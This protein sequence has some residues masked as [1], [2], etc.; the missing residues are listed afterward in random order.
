[1]DFGRYL[2]QLITGT[3][4]NAMGVKRKSNVSSSFTEPCTEKMGNTATEVKVIV[5]NTIVNQVISSDSIGVN[6]PR[7]KLKYHHM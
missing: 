4:G 7:R 3:N 6:R 5:H 1:M 2:A